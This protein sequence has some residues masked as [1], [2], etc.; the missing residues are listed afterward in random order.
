[1]DTALAQVIASII[2]AIASIVVAVIAG[3]YTVK[4][5]QM[6]VARAERPTPEV[7]RREI[8]WP[9]LAI[10]AL[11]LGILN[12]PIAFSLAFTG[13]SLSGVPSEWLIGD[14]LD[15]AIVGGVLWA[16]GFILGVLMRKA[17][18]GTG[19]LLLLLLIV[20]VFSAPVG[21]S[22]AYVGNWLNGV[23]DFLLFADSFDS[24]I[25]GGLVC[26]ANFAFG[27]LLANRFKSAA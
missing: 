16:V 22:L 23:P 1:M 25:V 6:K 26:A 19:K 20:G 7:V 11:T 13:N 3:Y 14:S 24:L 27:V 8:P 9:K 4:A 18:S 21:F 17:I 12:V 2:G 5:A 15:P 10:Y